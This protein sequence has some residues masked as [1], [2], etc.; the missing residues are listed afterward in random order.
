MFDSKKSKF[1]IILVIIGL[2]AAFVPGSALAATKCDTA[3]AVKRGDTLNSIGKKYGFA[4]NQIVQASKLGKPY[5]I[6]VGQTLCIPESKDNDAVKVDSKYTKV[7]AAYFTAGRTGDSV[8][9]YTFTYPSTK[10]IVKAAAAPN[11]DRKFYTLGTTAVQNNKSFKLKLPDELKN[12]KNLQV[13]L[14][15]RTTSYLQC[16]YVR[17]KS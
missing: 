17:P 3:Y 1:L 10:V 8:L 12:A 6:Y 14:K 15:D 4:A 5:T 2:L 13:C 7:P 16:V 9:I 11:T